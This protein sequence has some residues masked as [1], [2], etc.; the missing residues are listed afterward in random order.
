MTGTPANDL[1]E[2]ASTKI[3]RLRNDHYEGNPGATNS[4][5]STETPVQGKPLKR[6]RRDASVRDPR[7]PQAN[8]H[9]PKNNG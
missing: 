3:V 4:N 2:F 8:I 5:A 1:E 9:N 7:C 6:R